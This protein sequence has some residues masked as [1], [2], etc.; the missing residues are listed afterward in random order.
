MEIKSVNVNNSEIDYLK[1]WD[2]EKA[3]VVIPWLSLK[4][5]LLNADFVISAF[6][7]FTKKYTVYLFDR[8]KVIPDNYSIFDI[9][10]DTFYAMS[11]V[12]ITSCDV[13]WASQWWMIAQCIVIKHPNF[14]EKLILWSTSSKVDLNASDIFTKRINLA[15]NK[16]IS[17]L[18]EDMANH[19]Y[20][21]KTLED[22]WDILL[23][24]PELNWDE[25]DKFI[26]LTSSLINFNIES[27]LSNIKCKTFVIWSNDDLIF[28][29]KSSEELSKALGCKVFLYDNY[30]HAVYDEA[31]DYSDRMLKFLNE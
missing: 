5:V 28:W 21:K 7:K 15:R 23:S 3:F 9:A 17:E 4:S 12:W 14:I 22:Y 8:L 10:D 26:K 18:N 19:I 13:F 16:K 29:W 20:S 24:V 6:S 25:L 30:G 11:N 31:P 2:G 27:D 1:F